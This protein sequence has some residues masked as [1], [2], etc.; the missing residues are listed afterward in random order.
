MANNVVPMTQCPDKSYCCGEFTV[1]EECCRNN[2]GQ[3]IMES[4]SL[5]DEANPATAASP[6]STLLE[7]PRSS[8]MP[9]L[10]SVE[11][12]LVTATTTAAAITTAAATK[13]SSKTMNAATIVG[14]TIGII[15]ST[16]VLAIGLWPLI[17]HRLRRKRSSASPKMVPVK[18]PSWNRQWLESHDRPRPFEAQESM[19]YELRG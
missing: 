14:A 19:E 6:T 4:R 10:L 9:S 3:S 11:T 16:A 17:R 5:K 18:R 15:G 1:A 8:T 12:T 7:I 13:A 2:K